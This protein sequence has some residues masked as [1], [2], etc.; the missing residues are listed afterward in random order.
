MLDHVWIIPLIPAISFVL[1]LLF[2][3]KMPFKG[4]EI[5][6]AAIGSAFVLA[7]VTVVQWI[8][9]VESAT[10]KSEGLAALGRGV[11]GVAKGGE[12]V[13]EVEPIIHS[14]TWWQNGAAKFAIG[15]RT[16]GLVVMMLIVVTTISL[17]VHVYSTAYMRGDRRFTYYY[18]SL[19]LFSASMLM[20]VISSNLLQLLVGWEL[21]GLCSFML[22]G[23]WWEE[24][25][26]S[27]AALKAFLTTRTGDVGLLIGVIVCFFAAGTFDIG[28]INRY[29]IGGG[30]DHGL[31]LVAAIALMF[32]I[33]GKSGQF[34]LHTWLPDAMAGPTPVSAL[35]HAAT[36]VVA[37]VFLGAR[38]YPVFWNGFS[39]GGG[40]VNMMALVG[41]VTIIVGAALAFVQDDIKKVLA[42]STISQLGYMVMALG[43]GAWGAAVFH[44]FTHAFFKALLFLG[45]GAISHAAT[46][47][48]FDMKKE[49]GGLRKFMPV[50]FVTFMIGTLALAGIFPLAGF[51]SK[52][53]ILATANQGDFKVFMVIG[54]IGAGMT[55]AY[56]TRCVYL[57]FFGQ[58]RGHHHPHEAERTITVPLI[59]LAVL[60]IVAGLLNAAPFHI[61]KFTKWVDQVGPFPE[62]LH[63]KFDYL[64]AASSLTVAVVLI[65]IASFFWFKREE[66]GALHGLTERNR[67]A[68]AGFAFLA[69]KYYLDDLYEGVVVAGIKG[70]IA[71]ASYWLNQNVIDAFVK[72]TGRTAV[73]VGRATY[74]GLDRVVVDG[75]VNGLARETGAVG[76][77]LTKVQSGKLQRYALL[78]L[79]AVGLIGLA[80]FVYNVV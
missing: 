74:A 68:H 4:A 60:S 72:G 76:G 71:R 29:A 45:A 14:F 52:D 66:I 12:H 28:G 46:H 54:L 5:G 42:Y 34:F 15:A 65:G 22:I 57:T 63:P 58:Y 21:V 70:P 73:A 10:G 8:D 61:E 47:H 64:L 39:I 78:L 56:M 62:L 80:V 37:G 25:P 3:K 69:N 51:W 40:G 38:V 49:M 19:S 24:K 20:L 53:E 35:I 48:S 13:T 43:V 9:R 7:V 16:D 23:H 33:M 30:A 41:G 79:A 32:G 55:A 36:M 31:L 1:I 44:L 11:L 26:N 27:N 67:F 77:G 50:T 75:A 17:L 59:I 6:I 18:A 2:G